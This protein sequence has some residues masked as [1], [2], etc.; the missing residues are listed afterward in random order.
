MKE[1]R[2]RQRFENY[3]KSYHLLHKYSNNDLRSELELA[4]FIQ[5]FEMTFELSWKVMKDYLENEGY[6]LK[7]PR[8]TIKQAF[9]S[10]LIRAGHDWIEALTSRNETTQTY[11]E[12]KIVSLIEEIRTRYLPLFSELHEKLSEER[13]R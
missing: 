10:G 4:G 9:R 3:E 2:W 8:D 5:L 1:M 13:T 6:I 11:D 7:S 12:E